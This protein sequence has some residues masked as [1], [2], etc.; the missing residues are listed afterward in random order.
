MIL[1][2]IL[3][4]GEGTRMKSKYS[5]VTQKIMGKPMIEYIVQ[6]SKEAG[7]ERNVLIVGQN[8]EDLKEI[9]KDSLTYRKQEIGEGFPYGTGYAVQMAV[10]E[11]R[12]ED[13]VLILN[14]DIPLITG[15]SLKSFVDFHFES[16]GSA[17]VMTAFLDDPTSYGR[18][19]KCD[20][21]Y[22]SAIVEDKDCNPDQLKIKEINPGIYIFNGAKLKAALENLDDDNA[23][24]EM[25][26][27]D[28]VSI[29]A[30]QGEKISTFTLKDP[31]EMYGINSKD[32]LSFA[33][34]IMRKRIN[35]NHM[36]EGV[37]MEN[38]SNIYIEPGIEIGRD[39][40]IGSGA[41]ISGRTKIGEDCL[42]TGDTHI[43]DSVIGDRVK[44]V[45]SSIELSGVGDETTIGPYAHLRPGSDLSNN[46]HIGNFVEVKNSVIKEGTKAGHLA[47]IGDAD[48]GKDINI[49]CGAIFVNY[50]G[51]KKHRSKVGD[52]AFIGSNSNIVSPINVAEEGFIAAGST[53]IEDVDK[54]SLYIERGK[55]SQIKDWVYRKREGEE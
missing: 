13:D 41:R 34:E 45:S 3:A 10:D 54:G 53:V 44:I 35:T 33:Q 30:D 51:K 5:K 2:V 4:A 12:D 43:D 7:I 19:I 55:P 49:G 11:I 36:K 17:S 29:L 46:V 16:Q 27:T 14:G 18:I 8:E 25:Y 50:D 23:Q 20:Q 47:Y 26:I 22:L 37:L 39:T 31:D 40:Y 32:Q 28:V 9:F 52:G 15:Q 38:P 6:A 42:I 21:G 24:G 1:S 48:L